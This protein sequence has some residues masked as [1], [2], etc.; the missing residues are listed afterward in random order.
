MLIR[1]A[2]DPYAK[3][4]DGSLTGD[5]VQVGNALNLQSGYLCYLKL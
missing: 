3:N 2:K 1:D 5:V 4:S